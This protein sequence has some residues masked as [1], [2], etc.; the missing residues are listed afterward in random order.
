MTSLAEN[1]EVFDMTGDLSDFHVVYPN[2]FF[3]FTKIT[4]LVIGDSMVMEFP[5]MTEAHNLQK[6]VLSNNQIK[7]LPNITG[8]GFPEANLLRE[9]Y[10]INNQ[11]ELPVSPHV[12][13]G[14]QNLVTLDLRNSGIGLWPDLR[15]ATE[16]V[17]LKLSGNQITTIPISGSLGLP[18]N[19]ILR[20]L[21][22]GGNPLNISQL[23]SPLVG[24]PHLDNLELS[25]SGLETWPN[26]S[27]LSRLVNLNLANNRISRT[28]DNHGLPE[29][30]L[31]RTLNLNGNHEFGVNLSSTFFHSLPRLHTL[32]LSECGFN[33]FPNVSD[34]IETLTRIFIRQS[35]IETIDVTA[36][37]GSENP[38]TFTSAS[39]LIEL[40]MTVAKLR[41]FPSEIF[42][43]FPKLRILELSS[44]KD[45]FT[46]TVP[47]FALVQNTLEYL[48]LNDIQG[49]FKTVDFTH[50]FK[51][52]VKLKKLEMISNDQEHFP[53]P[54][55]FILKN[56]PALRTLDLRNNLISAVPDLSPVAVLHTARP[57]TVR[58]N[59]LSTL[60]KTKGLVWL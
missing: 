2:F 14:L 52:M 16:L 56:F 6:L 9:F 53:F 7:L 48:Y 36:L 23:F 18:I 42:K 47:N 38:E 58:Q 32:H 26:L 31:L 19:N 4:H 46:G 27:T 43:I 30:N 24:L 15:N 55:E 60:T 51:K 40:R 44:L 35:D 50:V 22:M 37:F 13:T 28:P 49:S 41:E 29:N 3:T 34:N 20:E 33:Q 11:L 8:L 1:L 54:A 45:W 5:N 17:H 25:N 10:F 39:S 12:W 21:L 59:L 57:L